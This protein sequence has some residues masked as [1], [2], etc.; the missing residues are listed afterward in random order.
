LQLALMPVI[1]E[2]GHCPIAPVSNAAHGAQ[3][4]GQ[5]DQKPDAR[6]AQALKFGPSGLFVV[7]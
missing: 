3:T 6:Q 1:V 4:N 5:P 7:R 2:V